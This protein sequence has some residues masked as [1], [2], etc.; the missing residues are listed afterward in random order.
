MNVGEVCLIS[1][2]KALS[3]ERSG[4]CL[5]CVMPICTYVGLHFINLA[6]EPLF[7]KHFRVRIHAQIGATPPPIK[8]MFSCLFVYFTP[9]SA[10]LKQKTKLDTSG[11]AH[12]SFETCCPALPV[13]FFLLFVHSHGDRMKASIPLPS[14]TYQ[15]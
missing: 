10:G 1:H 4:H 2:V 6:H 7:I 11:K 9:H 15:T 8:Q 13:V 14:A 5:P 3:P 12:Q